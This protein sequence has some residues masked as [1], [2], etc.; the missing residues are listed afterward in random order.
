MRGTSGYISNSDIPVLD[1]VVQNTAMEA[2]RNLLIDVLRECFS[3][4]R[5]YHWVPDIYGFNKVPSV[6]GMTPEAG[7]NDTATSRIYIGST[8]S[9]AM[10]M[11]PA[12]TVRQTRLTYKPVSFNQNKWDLEEGEVPIFDSNGDVTYIRR[13]VAY[14][15]V[16]LWESNFDVKI[17]SKSLEE[18]T[19][20]HDIIVVALQS[21]FRQELQQSGLFI[22]DV[23][24]SGEQTDDPIGK[25]PTHST[26]ISVSTLSEWRRRIPVGTV[27]ERLQICIDYDISASDLPPMEGEKR[28]SIQPSGNQKI[29][30]GAD[31]FSLITATNITSLSFNLSSTAVGTYSINALPGEYCYFA[32]PAKET[33]LS[34]SIGNFSELGQIVIDGIDYLIYRSSLTGLGN[35]TFN[36]S[37]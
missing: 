15:L 19:K 29:F 10:S 18:M 1:K 5:T 37:V 36:V 30:F 4:D 9:H 11:L 12:L 21:S 2:G 35:I 14:N 25:D 32:S 3:R 22:K 8:Y 31:S 16:G 24:S 26:V 6:L 17:R 20:L 23:S 7:V 13:P 27:V 33:N 34:F 28:L